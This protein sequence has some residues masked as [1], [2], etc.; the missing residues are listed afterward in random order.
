MQNMQTAQQ[1]HS[2]QQQVTAPAQTALKSLLTAVSSY[3]KTTSSAFTSLKVLPASTVQTQKKA[4]AGLKANGLMSK[5]T[6]SISSTAKYAINLLPLF[7]EAKNL[8]QEAKKASEV[9]QSQMQLIFQ[10]GWARK[11]SF[12]LTKTFTTQSF[13]RKLPQ[14][15]QKKTMLLQPFSRICPQPSDSPKGILI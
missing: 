1:A 8:L 11:L 4:S 12:P 10:P 6:D 2:S 15:R 5:P 13:R 14:A 7:S 9:F 3:A